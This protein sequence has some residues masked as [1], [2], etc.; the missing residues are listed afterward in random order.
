V[1]AKLQACD[2]LIQRAVSSAGSDEIRSAGIF[3][4][5]TDGITAFFRNKNIAEISG[6]V[7][8]GNHFREEAPGFPGSGIWIYNQMDGFHHRTIGSS[9]FQDQRVL[10]PL[11]ASQA[12]Y[13]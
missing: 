1:A 12:V 11:P 10:H 2:D 8:D 7:K 6:A 5:K 9:C 4:G 13:S 3:P